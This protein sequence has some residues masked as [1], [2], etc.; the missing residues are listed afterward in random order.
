MAEWGL[1]SLYLG[2]FGLP[3]AFSL[4]VMWANVGR[5]EK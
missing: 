1:F 3:M 2:I 4:G 5:E